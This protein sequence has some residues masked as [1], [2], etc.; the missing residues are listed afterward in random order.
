MPRM[1]F[2]LK[3]PGHRK[4]EATSAEEVSLLSSLEEGLRSLPDKDQEELMLM[5]QAKA[6]ENERFSSSQC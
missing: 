5:V 4:G 2:G 3:H 6:L 1:L